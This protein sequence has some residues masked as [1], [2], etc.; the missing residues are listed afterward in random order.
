MPES[1]TPVTINGLTAETDVADADLIPIWDASAS[2]TDKVTALT[3]LTYDVEAVTAS[4]A[5]TIKLRQLI[6]LNSG[7]VIAATISNAPAAGYELE[8][9]KIGSGATTHT[10]QLPSGVTWDG[11]NRT[12]NFNADGDNL[13]A[14]AISATRFLVTYNNSVTFSA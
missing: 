14:I 1:L 8:V 3:L 12:A 10:L 11:T 7:S 4:G 9:Y 2:T 6:T 13:R 5:V